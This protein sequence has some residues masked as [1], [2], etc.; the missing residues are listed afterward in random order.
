MAEIVGDKDVDAANNLLEAAN[1]RPPKHG[2]SA[3]WRYFGFQNDGGVITDDTHVSRLCF[4]FYL[5]VFAYLFI[6]SNR[7]HMLTMLFHYSGC[8]CCWWMPCNIE[9]LWQHNQSS[10]TLTNPASTSAF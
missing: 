4:I 7:T 10:I 2:T 3:V 9:I 8:L 6:V 5:F 1:L